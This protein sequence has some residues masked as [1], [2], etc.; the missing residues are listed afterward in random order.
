MS[1]DN[2]NPAPVTF[3]QPSLVN[4]I[5]AADRYK[6]EKVA[7]QNTPPIIPELYYRDDVL[8]KL[9]EGVKKAG[10]RLEVVFTYCVAILV[11]IDENNLKNILSHWNTSQLLFVKQ[12]L[13]Q[14]PD[15]AVA[16]LFALPL[17]L[18][19]PI[20]KRTTILLGVLFILLVLP[21]FNLTV[22]VILFTGT[23]LF[24]NLSD[25]APKFVVAAVT[26]I[27]I[28]VLVGV[29]VPHITTYSPRP[30]IDERAASTTVPPPKGNTFPSVSVG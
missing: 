28:F 1:T 18:G 29:Q 27:L 25:P 17:I 16:A 23:L 20:T 22:Y 4:A 5:R 15:K 3:T 13:L 14:Y 2:V 12:L 26:I 9:V 21:S 11:A 8:V 7:P 24:N 30:P 10:S 6:Q 19:A